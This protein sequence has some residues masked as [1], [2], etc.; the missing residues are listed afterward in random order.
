[1]ETLPVYIA[2]TLPDTYSILGIQLKPFSLGHLLHMRKHNIVY[3]N[4]EVTS[5]GIAD[6]ITAIVICSLTYEE[7]VTATRENL[8][9]VYVQK[10]CFS[11]EMV[12]K[13]MDFTKWLKGIGKQLRKQAKQVNLLTESNRFNH[14]LEEGIQ[15][16]A[17]WQEENYGKGERSGCH[18]TQ[19]LHDTLLSKGFTESCVMNMPLTEAWFHYFKLGEEGKVKLKTDEEL[20]QQKAQMV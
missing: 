20:E 1:M 13:T 15:E 10:H 7:F 2:A 17:Y 19:L 12:L 6:L 9:T 3:G 16:P 18:W 4:D 14:Y 8:I 11:K 5:G